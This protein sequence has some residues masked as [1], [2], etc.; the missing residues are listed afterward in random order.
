MNQAR[1]CVSSSRYLRR[2]TWRTAFCIH[3]LCTGFDTSSMAAFGTSEGCKHLVSAAAT[4]QQTSQLQET[5][6]QCYK[7]QRVFHMSVVLLV[8]LLHINDKGVLCLSPTE[9]LTGALSEGP[10][11][12]R[13]AS[14]L[15]LHPALQSL[16]QHHHPQPLQLPALGWWEWDLQQCAPLSSRSM[17]CRPTLATL[18]HSEPKSG[19]LEAPK[20]M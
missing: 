14:H 15:L 17:C 3:P 4:R 9:L 10:A 11:G 5:T 6:T 12:C 20:H 18:L 13:T 8:P 2:G 1:R 7:A 19:S 16:T